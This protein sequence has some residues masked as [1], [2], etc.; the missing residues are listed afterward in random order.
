MY[1][2]I[3]LHSNG[4]LSQGKPEVG[5][6]WGTDLVCSSD[7]SGKFNMAYNFCARQ[8]GHGNGSGILPREVRVMSSLSVRAV[9]GCADIVP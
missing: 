3:Q 5:A 2:I 7:K 9:G 8:G 6:S 4:Y 1:R